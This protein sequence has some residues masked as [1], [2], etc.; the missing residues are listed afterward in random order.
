MII[1]TRTE[2]LEAL[3]T[4]V[5]GGGVVGCAQCVC[6]G[7]GAGCLL[8]ALTAKVGGGLG[9]QGGLGGGGGVGWVGSGVCVC[10]RGGMSVC[11]VVGCA[12]R[13]VCVCGGG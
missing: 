12:R 8:E 6:G 5:C 9:V 10:V 4:K 7:G 3:T 2:L 11:F 13:G 1:K